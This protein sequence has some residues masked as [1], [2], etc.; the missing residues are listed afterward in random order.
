M[1]AETNRQYYLASRPAGR[2]TPEDVPCRD[3]PLEEPAP[4]EVVLRNLY[5]SLDPAIRGWMGDDPN[6]IEPIAIGDAVRSTVIG[7][8]VKSASDDFAEG[9]VAMT[10]GGWGNLHHGA[11]RRAQQ[12]GRERRYSPQLLSRGIGSHGPHGLF[13]PA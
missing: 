8:V 2:P 9:D 12:T 3:V 13:R 6:Y 1:N 11:R 5:I 4:G 7:R 10:M